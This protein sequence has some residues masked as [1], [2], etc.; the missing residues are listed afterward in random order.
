VSFRPLSL[1]DGS[2]R[3]YARRTLEDWWYDPIRRN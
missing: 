2:Q 1:P 3:H